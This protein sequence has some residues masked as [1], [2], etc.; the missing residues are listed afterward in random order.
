MA[1]HAKQLPPEPPK[2]SEAPELLTAGIA[3][4]PDGAYHVV[5]LKTR[6]DRITERKVLYSS[7]Y[8]PYVE[9]EYR[10]FSLLHI[11]DRMENP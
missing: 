7:T 4:T 5:A 11:L 3:R 8:R 2:Q 9:D 10:Q 1:N 6:G